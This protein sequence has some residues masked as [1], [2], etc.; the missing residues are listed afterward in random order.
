MSLL[1]GLN[2][3]NEIADEEDRVGGGF[4]PME[5]GIYPTKV[6]LAYLTES[7]G[8]AVGLVLHLLTTDDKTIRQTIYMTSGNAKGKKNFYIDKDGNKAYLPGFNLANSLAQL[9]LGKDIAALDTEE[10]VVSL[11]SYDAKAEVPTKVEMITPLLEQEIYAAIIKQVVDKNSKG[12]DGNYYPTGETREENEID[13]FFR[14]ADKMTSAELRA[15]ADEPKFYDTW[16]KKWTDVTKQKAKGAGTA[17][18]PAVNKTAAGEPTK[19]LFK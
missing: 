2:T 8:G 13:K 15:G 10:K 16:A 19:S 3:D 6:D 9:T 7:T 14:A 11:Y 1:A 5:S 4:T 12:D 17:G 18:A